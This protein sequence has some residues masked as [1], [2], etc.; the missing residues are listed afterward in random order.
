MMMKSKVENLS[1]K[2]EGKKECRK[3]RKR[4]TITSHLNN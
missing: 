3:E 1:S 4:N 2:I